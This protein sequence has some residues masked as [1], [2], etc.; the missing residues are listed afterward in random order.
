[1]H[2]RDVGTDATAGPLRRCNHLDTVPRGSQ[3]VSNESSYKTEM[4]DEMLRLDA[5]PREMAPM[6]ADEYLA[7]L[8]K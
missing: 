6:G 8:Y 2:K 5:G 4:V 3:L 7:W 1:M